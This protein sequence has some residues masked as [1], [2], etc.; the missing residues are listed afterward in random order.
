MPST[1][2]EGRFRYGTG[3]DSVLSEQRFSG[4]TAGNPEYQLTDLLGTV[5]GVEQRTARV[6]AAVVNTLQYDSFGKLISQSN[7]AKQ[8]CHGFIGRDIKPVVGLTYNP[9]RYY[10]TQSVR[11]ISQ[12]PIGFAA[13]DLWARQLLESMGLRCV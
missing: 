5:R 1:F 6:N 8:P 7:T 13:G 12:D 9:N 2:K 4:G 10:S 11:F 3:V